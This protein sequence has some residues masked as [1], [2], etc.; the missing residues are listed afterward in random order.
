MERGAFEDLE[1]TDAAGVPRV[2]EPALQGYGRATDPHALLTAAFLRR[3]AGLLRRIGETAP[4][5]ALAD[6]LSASDDVGGLADLLARVAPLAPP[7]DPFAA[8]RARGARA[9]GELLRRAG[10]GL[11]L[12]EAARRMG[13]TSQAV[14]TRR[15]RGTLLAVPQANGEWLYPGCQFGTDGPLPG[16]GGVLQAFAVRSPWTQ[17][18]VLLAPADALDGRTPLDALAAG[19][20]ERAAEA[21]STYG[22]QGA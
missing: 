9:K 10:G 3:Y 11:R 21:V 14:H 4:E 18:A 19:E 5:E 16:L 15:K 7:A 17:L 8:A 2:R 12:G 20:V 1:P 22:E 6:A 13:V